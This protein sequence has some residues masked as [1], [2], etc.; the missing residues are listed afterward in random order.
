V[1]DDEDLVRMTVAELLRAVG[2]TVIEAES[3]EQGLSR[4]G[5]E[6]V[7]LVITD[8][9]MPGMT[10]WEV[11]KGIKAARPRLPVILLTGWGQQISERTPGYSYVDQVLEK[12]VR[13]DDFQAGIAA[14]VAA[15]ANHE[16]GESPP[17]QQDTET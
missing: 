16:G 17:T 8:L 5:D 15:Y 14:A 9:G 3:G 11:A 10:G 13:L 6:P 1:I 4:L 12:P 2:H 7:D